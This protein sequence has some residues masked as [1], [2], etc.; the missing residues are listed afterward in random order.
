[1]PVSRP[2]PEPVPVSLPPPLPPAAEPSGQYRD[3]R[4]SR[5]RPV[6][7]PADEV[8]R[9]VGLRAHRA[10]RPGSSSGGADHAG[11]ASAHAECAESTE[12][13]DGDPAGST[14]VAASTRG[15]EAYGVPVRGG[16]PDGSGI[17]GGGVPCRSPARHIAPTA[18]SPTAVPTAQATPVG[19]CP[20]PVPAA[21]ARP[22]SAS[23]ATALPFAPDTQSQPQ[24]LTRDDQGGAA[25]QHQADGSG[26]AQLTAGGGAAVGSGG[27]R[28]G[29]GPGRNS[30]PGPNSRPGWRSDP[31]RRDVHTR[32][33]HPRTAPH[34]PTAP[35][36]PTAPYRVTGSDQGNRGN[37]GD[38]NRGR[39][40]GAP[41]TSRRARY[42]PPGQ[43][44]SSVFMQSAGRPHSTELT[45][46]GGE[47]RDGPPWP[48]A[49]RGHTVVDPA[50]G[51]TAARRWP[52]DVAATASS[53]E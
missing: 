23:I 46:Q 8:R 30:V 52:R 18:T 36:R 17:A 28:R 15:A 12:S 51:F 39:R 4:R 27:F 37:R 11:D 10:V 48:V 1:M 21:V 7:V 6:G 49:A 43:Q 14:V 42:R 16:R 47:A 38:G 45:G 40:S 35:C 19:K 13:T 34:G 9:V 44:P 26:T 22:S 33:G 20:W 5:S 31:G 29:G 2:V 3:A 41:R 53:G 25:G 50:S 32:Y 24:Q